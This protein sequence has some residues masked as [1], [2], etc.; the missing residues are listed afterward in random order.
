MPDK[1][2]AYQC[3]WDSSEE[4]TLSPPI[5][6][7][8]KDGSEAESWFYRVRSELQGWEVRS[9]EVKV[10]SHTAHSEQLNLPSPAH[11]HRVIYFTKGT[12]FQNK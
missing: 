8:S 2:E 10:T 5:P 1:D 12:L 9:E 3:L 6:I 4:L 11:P 7:L